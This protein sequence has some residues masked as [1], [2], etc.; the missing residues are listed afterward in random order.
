MS[1][2]LD[3]PGA[4]GFRPTWPQCFLG[5]S[6]P[7]AESRIVLLGA[8]FDGTVS[9]RPGSR[10]APMQMRVESMGFETY[11]PS[12]DADLEDSAVH[13]AGDLEFAPG[14]AAAALDRIE[15]EVRRI[16]AE[17]RRPFL[18]GG[19]HLVTLGALRAAAAA[20]PGL[21]VV[22]LD[23]HS[24]TRADYLGEELSHACVIRRAHDLLGDGRIHSFGIRSGTREE[25]AW[26]KT[27]IDLHRD[28]TEGLGELCRRLAAEGAPVYLTVD[29]DVLDPS[30]FPGTGTPEPGGLTFRELQAAFDA[31]A[32]THPNL[33]GADVVELAPQL[34]ASGISTAAACRALREMLL[35]M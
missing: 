26:S 31:I 5:C 34:D 32:A 28:T 20:H 14:N 18:V 19:E 6:T 27:H 22:H 17:G 23:A 9:Y 1:V 16:Y 29:L 8:P 33:V 3:Y 13:D 15:G 12:R 11:S 30:G 35:L 21:H 4:G 10:F 7:R 2:P 24:D 25:F